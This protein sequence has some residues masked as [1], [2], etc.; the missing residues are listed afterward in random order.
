MVV[1]FPTLCTKHQ[2]H[3]ALVCGFSAD[4][5]QAK[6]EHF[7]EALGMLWISLN[8]RVSHALWGQHFSILHD[9]PLPMEVHRNF[10]WLNK[11][12][13]L[14]TLTTT[15]LP[16]MYRL[17]FYVCSKFAHFGGN[18]IWHHWARPLGFYGKCYRE[19]FWWLF[20]VP[21][22]LSH[23]FDQIS[24]NKLDFPWTSD[25]NHD[26]HDL[27]GNGLLL[28]TRAMLKYAWNFQNFF[29]LKKTR[30]KNCTETG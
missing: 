3:V 2:Q 5:K 26:L 16:P 20:F 4:F 6:M 22:N 18:W 21:I 10:T 17:Q 23:Y 11:L 9:K 29:L 15:R 14:I 30:L 25:C 12:N 24:R 13:L 19:H 28:E 1:K 7:H 8:A 27:F